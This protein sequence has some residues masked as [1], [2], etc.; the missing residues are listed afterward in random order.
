MNSSLSHISGLQNA[1][2]PQETLEKGP[3]IMIE[4]RKASRSGGKIH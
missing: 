3:L 1:K 2:I 4:L